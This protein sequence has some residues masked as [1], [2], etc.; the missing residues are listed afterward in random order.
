MAVG[1]AA[2]PLAVTD[3]GSEDLRLNRS[4]GCLTPDHRV[5][6]HEHSTH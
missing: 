1:H 6:V 4:L 2:L 3:R 5:D